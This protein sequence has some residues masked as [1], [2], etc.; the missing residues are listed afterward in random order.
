[1]IWT[2]LK[3]EGNSGKLV[4]HR[5]N[6]I[7]TSDEMFRM[8]KFQNKYPSPCKQ[9]ST[10]KLGSK[11]VSVLLSGMDNFFFHV[12]KN[13]FVLR[14]IICERKCGEKFQTNSH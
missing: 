10:G 2:D 13:F 3:T 14:K 4:Q 8:C 9:S 7:L 12:G 5:K 1:M 6:I 11:F